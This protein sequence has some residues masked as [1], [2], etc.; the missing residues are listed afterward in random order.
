MTLVVC[1]LLFV[2]YADSQ[3]TVRP[4]F[5]KTKRV[6]QEEALAV[7]KTLYEGKDVDY[8]VEVFQVKIDTT[9]V[10]II[11][12]QFVNLDVWTFFV[13]RSRWKTGTIPVR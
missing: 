13:D 7:V 6:S 11:K 9:I 2:G 4:P 5:S 10:P 8:Y 12:P 3:I 1:L